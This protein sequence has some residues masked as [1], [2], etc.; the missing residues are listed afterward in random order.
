MTSLICACTQAKPLLSQSAGLQL[1][2]L[3]KWKTSR[4]GSVIVLSLS[5]IPLRK[6][7]GLSVRANWKWAGYKEINLPG[8]AF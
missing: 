5:A 3:P 2:F 8:T 7:A 1:N 6:L 4:A